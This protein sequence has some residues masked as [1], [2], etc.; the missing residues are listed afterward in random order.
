VRNGVLAI[1]P[2]A[3]VAPNAVIGAD[4]SI[5]PYCV[6]GPD[7]AIGDGCKLVANVHLAGHTTIGANTAIYPFT[8]LGTPPQS[9]HYRGGATSLVIGAN[10]QIR[11]SVT[12]NTGTEDGGGVTTVGD[13]CFMMAGSHV[14]HD[15]HVGNHVVFANN[16]V[17]GGHCEIGDHVFLGGQA[18]VHQ[19]VRVGEGVMIAG[20]TA[21][22]DDAVPF[23]YVL[24][25]IGRLV[26]LNII[27]M[28][29]RGIKRE[30]IQAVR[31][32][33]KM[34][35]EGEGKF[36]DRIERVAAEHGAVAEVAKMVAFLRAAKRPVMM[37]SPR[38]AHSADAGD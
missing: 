37:T 25:P 33:Y 11:E 14:G 22:R 29:R 18:A 8:S 35:F 4:V 16:A 7:V 30:S 3:R 10:C 20:Y 2:T 15:C 1:D 23:G 21:L 19:R 38:G 36:A 6:V 31:A 27:G 12:I 24:H 34:L 26:G 17:I 9:V 5:G 28:R 13:E 32:A